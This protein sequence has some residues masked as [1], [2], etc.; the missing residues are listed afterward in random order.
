MDEFGQVAMK[1]IPPNHTG[2]PF[3]ET[4]G[5]DVWL[6]KMCLY[7]VGLLELISFQ[8]S[9]SAMTKKM[10]SDTFS[11]SGSTAEQML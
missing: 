4:Q 3:G 1:C 7:P 2:K 9:A 11:M 10:F 6:S 5:N 8:A